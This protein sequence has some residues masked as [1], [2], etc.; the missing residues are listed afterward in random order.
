[1]TVVERGGSVRT[2]PVANVTGNTLKGFIRDNVATTSR[3]ITDE[4]P[5][6]NGIG[7][8]YDGGHESVCHSAKEYVRGDIFTATPLKASSPS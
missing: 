7:A 6:Y 5:A 3:I 2:K 4:N 1:V 8:E